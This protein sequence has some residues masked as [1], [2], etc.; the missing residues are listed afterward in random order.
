[1]EEEILDLFLA[2]N[3]KLA[4]TRKRDLVLQ[5]VAL[6]DQRPVQTLRAS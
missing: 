5:L 6:P 1:M 3:F 4:L 2:H